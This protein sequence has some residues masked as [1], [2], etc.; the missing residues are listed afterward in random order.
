[1]VSGEKM[2]PIGDDLPVEDPALDRRA[3]TLVVV[4]PDPSLAMSLLHDLVLGAETR[5]DLLLLPVD[6]ASLD[7]EEKLPGVGDE[8][9]GWSDAR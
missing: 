9:P 7:G 2:V 8:C 1:M 3:A 5:D 4:E 6:Q